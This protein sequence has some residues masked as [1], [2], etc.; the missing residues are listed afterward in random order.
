VFLAPSGTIRKQEKIMKDEQQ[1]H[2]LAGVAKGTAVTFHP[3]AGGDLTFYGTFCEV[4]PGETVRVMTHSGAYYYIRPDA[5]V[6]V[7]GREDVE[8]TP[9]IDPEVFKAR[10]AQAEDFPQRGT[11]V[12]REAE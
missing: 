11:Y 8:V 7:D 12:D 1:A 5:L 4:L 10:M 6:T 3:E 9:A 2:A